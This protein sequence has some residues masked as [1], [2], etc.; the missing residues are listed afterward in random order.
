MTLAWFGLNLTK[1]I[2]P[3]LPIISKHLTE[4]RDIDKKFSVFIFME[5]WSA[6]K[7]SH[8]RVSVESFKNEIL[9]VVKYVSTLKNAI[10]CPNWPYSKEYLEP[11]QTSTM[12]FFYESS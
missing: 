12:E 2:L 1:L 11:G 8:L 7:F 5:F 4:F 6:Q 10:V 3:T 9:L